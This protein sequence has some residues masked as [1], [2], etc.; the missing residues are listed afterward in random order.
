MTGA[1]SPSKARRNNEHSAYNPSLNQKRNEE[2]AMVRDKIY[3][4]KASEM[5][6]DF[7]PQKS[8]GKAI[9]NVFSGDV[10]RWSSESKMYSWIVSSAILLA[11]Q[12]TP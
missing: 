5:I 8:G 9:P 10:P 2:R 1:N 3:C 6:K 4:I 7:F 12:T 11:R